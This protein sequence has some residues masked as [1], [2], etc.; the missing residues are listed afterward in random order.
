MTVLGLILAGVLIY[1][2]LGSA[3]DLSNHPF[4]QESTPISQCL[5]CHVKNIKKNPIMPHR[6]MD[7]CNFC[8]KAPQV[9]SSE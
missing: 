6:P 7:S 9:D 3:P 8:H 2:F 4:H 5:D 1:G